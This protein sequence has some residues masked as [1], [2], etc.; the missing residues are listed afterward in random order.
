M[1]Y[2]HLHPELNKY[3]TEELFLDYFFS[4]GGVLEEIFHSDVP[5]LLKY[6]VT[7]LSF[8]LFLDVLC[9][10]FLSTLLLVE[11]VPESK[12]SYFLGVNIRA[13]GGVVAERA[14]CSK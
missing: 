11:S 3:K 7:V 12:H 4:R 8:S 1:F 6:Q 10:V 5:E 2:C 13:T 14:Q 9:Q